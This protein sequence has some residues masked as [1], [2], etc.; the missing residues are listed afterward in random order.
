MPVIAAVFTE[1][2]ALESTLNSLYAMDVASENVVIMSP[3]GNN[4]LDLN[5]VASVYYQGGTIADTGIG[6]S[7]QAFYNNLL[8]EGKTLVFV[9][10]EMDKVNSVTEA[11]QGALRVNRL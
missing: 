3:E 5:N 2:N 11:I 9:E 1:E 4:N 6:L 8:D 10:T 7:E